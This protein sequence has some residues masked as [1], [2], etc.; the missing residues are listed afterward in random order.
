MRLGW[1]QVL[2]NILCHIEY[3]LHYVGQRE[4]SEDKHGRKYRSLKESLCFCFML[5]LAKIGISIREIRGG[6][7][8]EDR[9]AEPST[10]SEAGCPCGEVKCRGRGSSLVA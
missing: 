1:G 8:T 10:G 4:K 7:E 9:G 5:G 2:K 6:G 3:K